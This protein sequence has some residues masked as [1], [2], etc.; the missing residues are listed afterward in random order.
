MQEYKDYYFK[1]NPRRKK[2][3]FESPSGKLDYLVLS[4]N[5]ILVI[6][7]RLSMNNKKQKW[8]DFGE[9]LCKKYEFTN[10]QI[11]NA[12]VEVRVFSESKAQKDCD[13]VAGGFKFL[14]DGLFVKSKM[15]I[16]DNYKYI[17]PLIV[18]IDYDKINPRTEIRISTFNEKIKDIYEKLKIHTINWD[19]EI[20]KLHKMEG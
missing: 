19:E 20:I 9:W 15:F 5:N 7:N 18:V 13:N 8:G 6:N 10:M 17:N 12:L 14:S 1:S 16:D 2:F 4:L 11:Q 3:P